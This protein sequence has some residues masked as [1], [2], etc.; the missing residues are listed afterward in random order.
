MALNEGQPGVRLLVSRY[1]TAWM[2]EQQVSFAFTTYRA[3]RLFLVG[4]DADNNIAAQNYAFPR[5]M[6]LGVAGERVHLAALGQVWRLWST[7]CDPASAM[8]RTTVCTCH[9]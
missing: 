6:G 3:G 7:C 1:L 9:G 5:C 2:A 4:R 8:A